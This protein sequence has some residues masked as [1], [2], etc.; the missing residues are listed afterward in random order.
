[1][2]SNMYVARQFVNATHKRLEEILQEYILLDKKR[3][4][5]PQKTHLKKI[6]PPRS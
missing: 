6:P 1:M 3:G 2:C 4:K 5:K